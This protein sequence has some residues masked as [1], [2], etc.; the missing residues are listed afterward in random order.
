MPVMQEKELLTDFLSGQKQ[1]TALY[2][3][4]AGECVSAQLRDQMLSIL[5]DEHSIQNDIFNAM[6][7]RG[8][9]PV[10]QADA[11]QINSTKQKLGIS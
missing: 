7:T 3:S 9:Y 2:N 10:K 1:I 5:K 4:Y 11:E 8:F 6:S